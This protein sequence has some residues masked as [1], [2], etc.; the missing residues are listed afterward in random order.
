ML[1]RSVMNTT[2]ELKRLARE[3]D[4]TFRAYG[5]A[6]A[7]ARTNRFRVEEDIARG[8]KLPDGV[9]AAFHDHHRAVVA[10]WR[11]RGVI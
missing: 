6:C 1:A 9:S 4:D 3:A 7:A 11:A 2:P 8:K 5:R 10:Y